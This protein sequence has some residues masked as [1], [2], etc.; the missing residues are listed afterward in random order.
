M[1]LYKKNINLKKKNYSHNEID[2]MKLEHHI[3]NL[4]EKSEIDQDL[5]QDENC[6]I[7]I[8]LILKITQKNIGHYNVSDVHHQ[9]HK[10]LQMPLLLFF[11]S[12][13]SCFLNCK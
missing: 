6:Y 2:G 4:A 1:K 11:I 8:V 5:E 9:A 10:K 7:Q 13:Y 3:Q 12:C